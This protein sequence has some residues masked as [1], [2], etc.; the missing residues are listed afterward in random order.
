MISYYKNL[1]D[2]FAEGITEGATVYAG[3][4]IGTIS[5]SAIIEISDEPHLHFELELDGK[6]IDPMTMLDYEESASVSAAADKDK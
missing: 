2:E 3:Q 4:P 1:S 6:A 5:D